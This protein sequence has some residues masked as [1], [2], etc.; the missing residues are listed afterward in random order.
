MKNAV[1]V[2]SLCSVLL[3]GLARAEEADD[4]ADQL[5]KNAPLKCLDEALTISNSHMRRIL[6]DLLLDGM[7]TVE[8][9]GQAWAPGNDNY[10]QAHDLL[11]MALQDEE[12]S[13]GP[14]LD[15]GLRPLLRTMIKSWTPAQRAEYLAFLKQKAGRLYW[16]S[17]LDGAMCESTIETTTKPPHPLSSGADKHRLDALLIGI[18]LRKMTME[19]EFNLLPKEQSAKMRKLAPE[20]N[21]SL[22]QAHSVVAQVDIPRAKQAYQSVAPD[23]KKIFAAYKP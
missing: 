13:N 3:P 23:L 8:K 4:V 2:L 20:L 6:P 21:N 17:I 22:H 1:A 16:D 10:R 15:G 19:T 12:A 18:S 7:R 14:L 9:L 11:E 5:L